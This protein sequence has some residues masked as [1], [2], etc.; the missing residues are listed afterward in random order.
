MGLFDIFIKPKT[1]TQE[2]RIDTVETLVND[3]IKSIDF[4][5]YC[6]FIE[7][8]EQSFTSGL[9]EIAK[10]GSEYKNETVSIFDTFAERIEALLRGKGILLIRAERGNSPTFKFISQYN[11]ELFTHDVF[12]L[13]L[14]QEYGIEPC[15]EERKNVLKQSL[16]AEKVKDTLVYACY[17]NNTNNILE[18]LKNAKQLQLDKKL[19]YKGTPLG[20]CAKNN[21]VIAFKAVTEAGATISKVSLA[22]TPLAIAFNYSPDIVK[23]IYTNFREQFNKEVLKKGFGIAVNTM[24]AEI[25]ELLL[26]CGCDI[27][28][29]DKPF[30]PLHNFADFNNIVGLKFLVEHGANINTKNQHKQTPLDRAKARDSQEAIDFLRLHGA[31]EG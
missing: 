2:T 22:D 18:C 11:P 28:C 31:V 26:N 30:P 17:E 8:T 1:Y 15:D 21:N 29:S 23:Y 12:D 20:L 13:I 6:Y 25:L 4:K 10:C 19:E 14:F 5:S 27:N 9:Y 24:D 16:K 3:I 7:A